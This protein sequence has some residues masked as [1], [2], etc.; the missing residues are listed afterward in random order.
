MKL[1]EHQSAFSQDVARLITRINVAGYHCTFGEAYRTPEQ[2]EIYVKRGTGIVN[3]LHIKRLAIDLNLFDNQFQYL[4]DS[5]PYEQFG[6]YWES[7]D[8]FNRWGGYFETKY[9]G[10]ISDSNHFERKAE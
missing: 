8:S 2:A 6:I 10:H 7:L 1:S 3:S 9:G 4:T 5:K